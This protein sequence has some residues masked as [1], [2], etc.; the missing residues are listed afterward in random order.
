MLSLSALSQWL[1]LVSL[2]GMITNHNNPP[3]MSF[4]SNR[5][6]SYVIH[7]YEYFP[8]IISSSIQACARSHYYLYSHIRWLLLAPAITKKKKQHRINEDRQ[9]PA[10]K[11]CTI[12]QTNSFSL[13]P[14]IA[15]VAA[16]SPSRLR[17]PLRS[18][19]ATLPAANPAVCNHKHRWSPEMC[20]MNAFVW[21]SVRVSIHRDFG[22]RLKTAIPISAVSCFFLLHII[23]VYTVTLAI[24]YKTARTRPTVLISASI[25]FSDDNTMLYCFILRISTACTHSSVRLMLASPTPNLS[26]HAHGY[27]LLPRRSALNHRRALSRNDMVRLSDPQPTWSTTG[28][29]TKTENNRRDGWVSLRNWDKMHTCSQR[30]SLQPSVFSGHTELADVAV[31]NVR[32]YVCRACLIEWFFKADFSQKRANS[33]IFLHTKHTYGDSHISDWFSLPTSSIQA[34]SVP[35]NAYQNICEHVCGNVHGFSWSGM[36]AWKW[37]ESARLLARDVRSQ[38]HIGGVDSTRR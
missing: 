7:T 10:S 15:V 18:W 26:A 2:T 16:A 5:S 14:S 20:E 22:G 37:L 23:L 17:S 13:R 1:S 34:P 27:L 30:K 4:F 12:E 35:L 9:A 38:S 28:I 3:T 31:Y 33:S 19:M 24:Q 6:Y 25:Y 32:K 8:T 11:P 21:V 36:C 29:R